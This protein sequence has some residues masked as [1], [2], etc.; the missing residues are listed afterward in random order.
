MV[1]IE[2]LL[3]FTPLLFEL[4]IESVNLRPQGLFVDVP[5]FHQLNK[6]S[7]GNA[8]ITLLVSPKEED[9]LEIF[10]NDVAPF[11]EEE[12]ALPEHA[13][14]NDD[15]LEVAGSQVV[16]VVF[17]EEDVLLEIVQPSVGLSRQI[18]CELGS[19]HS[20][21]HLDGPSLK[22]GLADVAGHETVGHELILCYLFGLVRNLLL[23][24]LLLKLLYFVAE[25]LMLGCLLDRYSGR[26]VNSQ[27]FLQKIS[28]QG[29]DVGFGYGNFLP[30]L[31]EDPQ[32]FHRDPG[33]FKE[34]HVVDGDS[35]RPDICLEGILLLSEDLWAHELD[36]S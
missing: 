1:G 34:Q 26:L 25:V 15:L 18:F 30:D 36:G 35:Q 28:Q 8:D 27:H 33:H 2:V 11:D 6:L 9:L 16:E 3:G 19:P 4:F 21:L 13:F 7:L 32:H 20:V 10:G 29:R 31:L 22:L 14:R 24:D 23:C 5:S 17:E 12:L